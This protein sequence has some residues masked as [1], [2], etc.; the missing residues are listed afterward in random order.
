MTADN[1]KRLSFKKLKDIYRTANKEH[2]DASLG[3]RAILGTTLA[4]LAFEWSSGNESMLGFV[5]GQAYERTQDPLLTSLAAGGASF[6]EQGL[7]GALMAMTVHNY[8][9]VTTKVREMVTNGEE[10]SG[11]FLGRYAGAMILGTG[12]ELAKE[13]ALRPHDR[14]ENLRRA[15]GNATMIAT[16]NTLLV[17]GLSGLVNLGEEHGFETASETAVNVAS[18]PLTYAAL[19]GGAIGYNRAKKAIVNRRNNKRGDERLPGT[20][21]HI[22]EDADAY[23]WRTQ[24]VLRT[25]EGLSVTVGTS[26]PEEEYDSL[27]HMVETGFQDLN[28]RSYEKQDMTRDELEADLR[29]EHVLKYVA[30]DADANPLGLLTVHV[31]LDYI[32]WTDTSRIEAKQSEVDPL[33]VPYYVG[34][35]V[36]PVDERGTGTAASLLRGAF[37]HFRQAN[38]E[39]GQDSLVF[40]DCAH[41]NYPWLG[42]FIQEMGMP[43]DEHPDLSSEV[44]ELYTSAWLK[45][46]DTIRKVYGP[47]EDAAGEVLDTQHYYAVSITK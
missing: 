36:V 6:A 34:T 46:G 3:K 2:K 17:G 14:K 4:G 20:S 33:A 44:E 19:I 12:V 1:E 15:A 47:S 21:R 22:D 31:G 25:A 41:A 38:T 28:Q 26:V 27:W 42:E 43:T 30:R 13:N 39:R 40:F 18:N 11:T 29:S 16:S 37:A 45:D 8:P 23:E 35:V 5:S 24:E 9:E 32:T 7:I 10:S